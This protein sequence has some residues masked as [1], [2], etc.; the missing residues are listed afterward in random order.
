LR[1]EVNKRLTVTIAALGIL[2]VVVAPFAVNTVI[3]EFKAPN[4]TKREKIQESINGARELAYNLNDKDKNYILYS[5]YGEEVKM[6][7]SII[8]NEAVNATYGA[9]EAQTQDSINYARKLIA[10][11]SDTYSEKKIDMSLQLDTVQQLLIDTTIVAVKTAKMSKTQRDIDI[12]RGLTV[13][14]PPEFHVY[15]LP[16]LDELQQEYKD[17]ALESIVVAE[18]SG[19]KQDYNKAYELYLDLTKVEYNSEVK[20]WVANELKPRLDKVKIMD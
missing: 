1:K 3:R 11:L 18:K 12:A 9:V 17:R 20:L 19:K 13:S 8:Y 5:L 16:D 14:L 4:L 7:Q 10:S 2:F 6:E 15:F